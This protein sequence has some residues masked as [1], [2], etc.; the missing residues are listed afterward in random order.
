[1]KIE[2]GVSDRPTGGGTLF[3]IIRIFSNK[4]SYLYLYLYESSE[5][6]IFILSYLTTSLSPN[7][8]ILFDPNFG[9][10]C[11]SMQFTDK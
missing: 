11:P 1:M 2:L 10:L 3:E 8:L 9:Y 5:T 6:I 4:I 7:H